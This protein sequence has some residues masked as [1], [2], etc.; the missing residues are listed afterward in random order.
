MVNEGWMSQGILGWTQ[1]DVKN[2]FVNNQAA[3]MTN[4]PW[5]IPVIEEEAPDLKWN[6]V[7][8]PEGEESA[9]ILGGENLAIISGKENVDAAWELL[10]WWQRP[11]NLKRY[12]IQA[13]KLPSRQDLAED[14]HWSDD[15]VLG[16]FVEQLRVA[17]ARAY[18]P[19]YP[20]ISS[21][22]QDAMQA[23]VSGESTIDEALSRA[24]EQITPLLPE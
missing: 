11:E 21:A 12:L 7:P 4:G 8:L 18:G 13:G 19:N 16:V 1:E 23:A 15:P 3:M 6:V 24:Q 2:Q 17:R 14:P 9:S 22:I 20:E 10:T 5:Q